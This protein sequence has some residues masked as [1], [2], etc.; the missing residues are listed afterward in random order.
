MD[1]QLL[2]AVTKMREGKEEGFNAVYAATHNH[3]YFRAKQTMR[4]EQDAEDLVQIV[5]T[6]AFRN[7]ASLQTPD[8]LFGWLD[9]I[10]YNQGM[11]MFRKKKD[12]LLSE[13]GE[14]VFDTLETND[15]ASMP[16]PTMDEK[17]TGNIIKGLIAELPEA[18]RAS[19]TAYYFDGFSVGKIAEMME[20]SEGTIKS[21][22]NYA[23]QYLKERILQ[24]EKKEGYALHVFGLPA[25]WYALWKLSKETTMTAHAAEA[26]YQKG[27]ASVGLKAAPLT[28]TPA[29][30]NAGAGMAQVMPSW[31]STVAETLTAAAGG[32]A[33]VAGGASSFGSA[34]GS[35]SSVDMTGGATTAA[36][37]STAATAAAGAVSIKAVIAAV[38]AAVV[39][40]AGA[41]IVIPRVIS[42]RNETT[43]V[44]DAEEAQDADALSAG[45]EDAINAAEAEAEAE[46]LAQAERAAAEE[47]ALAG[48]E[49]EDA[50]ANP[51]ADYFNMTM[52]EVIE[53]LGENYEVVFYEGG[54]SLWYEDQHLLVIEQ[55]YDGLYD[56]QYGTDQ[57][58]VINTDN[59]PGT[60]LYTGDD[61][62]LPG[63]RRDTMPNITAQLD[64]LGIEYE[65]YFF[66]GT[67]NISGE[68][69]HGINFVYQG[70]RYNC[71][72][73]G[74]DPDVT[75]CDSIGFFPAPESQ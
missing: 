16:E 14:G 30:A 60:I 20:C 22:L 12:M 68:D 24:K 64:R 74:T 5:Y 52:G 55:W 13:E 45:E 6:E 49:E 31:V 42:D 25:L 56:G 9:A 11:K 17:E 61:E 62:V 2:S 59:N 47:E 39:V 8:A 15:I 7:I 65:T 43:Q 70:I 27:C 21:R 26:V 57:L 46:A 18:Q 48:E 35:A 67:E 54:R 38:A 51:M 10:T 33:A 36:T 63:V 3:V 41:A 19:L 34:A 73:G 66:S 69:S 28:M 40:I 75:V 72:W 44:A 4:H 58:L 50:P 37:G 29:I 23:R 71:S 1:Q 32:S 53:Q